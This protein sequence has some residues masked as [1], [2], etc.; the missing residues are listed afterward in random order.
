M[1]NAFHDGGGGGHAITFAITTTSRANR[2]R[3]SMGRREKAADAPSGVRGEEGNRK[4]LKIS[5][6]NRNNEKKKKRFVRYL[7][8]RLF[9]PCACVYKCMKNMICGPGGRTME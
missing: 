8:L 5:D 4:K 3:K 6:K 9:P 7:H 2:T 1:A